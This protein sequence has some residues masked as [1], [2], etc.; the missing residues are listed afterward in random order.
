MTSHKLMGPGFRRFSRPR[1]WARLLGWLR[2]RFTRRVTVCDWC[3]NMGVAERGHRYPKGWGAG[4][5]PY[6]VQWAR[7]RA[8]ELAE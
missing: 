2:V 8:E 7:E 1:A 6:H 4:L 5:C 3:Y